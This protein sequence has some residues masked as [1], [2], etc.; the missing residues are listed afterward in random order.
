MCPS[1]RSGHNLQR[2][3]CSKLDVTN[4]GAAAREG[5]AL[6]PGKAE[7]NIACCHSRE[8]TGVLVLEH[9]EPSV[10]R[11]LVADNARSH[12]DEGS[13][14][15]GRKSFRYILKSCNGVR[16]EGCSQCDGVVEGRDG[17]V[18]LA[19]LDRLNTEVA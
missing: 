15:A 14:A 19:W 8:L 3:E 6:S 12:P 5:E 11:T 7:I 2:Q 4:V 1:L 18:V 13:I 10:L 17:E 9:S 16:R